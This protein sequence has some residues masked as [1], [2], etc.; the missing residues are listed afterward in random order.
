MLNLKPKE[1]TS[2]VISAK[3]T[4]CICDIFLLAKSVV[5]HKT[6]S[7]VPTFNLS[8]NVPS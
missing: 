1:S 7:T 4:V 2:Q 6:R 5:L 8:L 3:K